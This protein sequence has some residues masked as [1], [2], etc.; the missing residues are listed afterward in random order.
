MTTVQPTTVP[1]PIASSEAATQ[2]GPFGVL[3]LVAGVASVIFG[4]TLVVPIAAVVLGIIGLRRDRTGR[5]LSWWGIGL[6]GAV[7]VLPVLG[8]VLAAAV[9]LPFLVFAA[10]FSR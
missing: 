3:S 8:A 9:L 1:A 10:L 6:G 2:S 7:I 5:A 4:Y